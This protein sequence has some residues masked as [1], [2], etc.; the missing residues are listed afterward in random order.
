M[1]QKT[2]CPVKSPN[3]ES[4]KSHGTETS[5]NEADLSDISPSPNHAKVEFDAKNDGNTTDIAG[6]KSKQSAEDIENP[7]E[8][9]SDD[10]RE[11][12]QKVLWLTFLL[13][14]PQNLSMSNFTA[15][16]TQH[17]YTVCK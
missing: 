7:S 11:S 1:A 14:D 8:S 9:D 17:K 4:E 13:N 2:T 12:G 16:L 3:F 15:S 5:K 6:T 10:S